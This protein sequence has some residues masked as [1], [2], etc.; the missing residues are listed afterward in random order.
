MIRCYKG[1]KDYIKNKIVK[2]DR[3]KELAKYIEC[4]VRIDDRLYKR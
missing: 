2:E 3:F 1:I 4:A